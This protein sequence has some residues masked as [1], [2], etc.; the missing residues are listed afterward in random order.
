MEIARQKSFAWS[1]RPNRESIG[2]PYVDHGSFD[3]IE[4]GWRGCVHDSR[5]TTYGYN[6]EF[7]IVDEPSNNEAY[8]WILNKPGVLNTQLTPDLFYNMKHLLMINKILTSKTGFDIKRR[9]TCIV[10]T[11]IINP[12]EEM[13]INYGGNY[14]PDEKSKNI[15]FPIENLENHLQMKEEI[16]SPYHHHRHRSDSTGPFSESAVVCS[17]CG[18]FKSHL[19]QCGGCGN[20]M[21]CNVKCQKLHWPTHR[22]CCH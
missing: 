18:N 17:A 5:G 12:D 2:K 1:Y 22:F 9:L 14:F 21:Y 8:E 15:A 6:S 3:G 7:K 10:A 19:S 20:A 11:K 13:F 4:S 16:S